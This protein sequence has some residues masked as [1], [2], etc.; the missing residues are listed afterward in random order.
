[1][2]SNRY[3]PFHLT[4]SKNNPLR[5]FT[6][7][8]DYKGA[9]Q[10]L[11]KGIVLKCFSYLNAERTDAAIYHL[12]HGRRS[13]QTIHDAHL[14]DLSEFYGIYRHLNKQKFNKLIKHLEHERLIDRYKGTDIFE[15]TER[16]TIWL[17]EH[18]HTMPFHYYKGLQYYDVD[19]MFFER[20]LLLTQVLTNS[21]NQNY[22]Y[23]P[24]IDK[25]EITEWVKQTYAHMKE[26]VHEHL[27]TLYIELYH[28]LNLLN[29]QEANLFVDRLTGYRHYGLS[30]QQLSAQYN[31]SES[32]IYLY[33]TGI[34]HRLLDHIGQDRRTYPFLNACIQDQ[35]IYQTM[36]QSA[37]QTE[38]LLS[39]GLDPEA[40]A[41]FRRLTI[42][43]IYDHIVEIALLRENFN[44]QPYVSYEEQEAIIQA[45]KQA[46]STKLKRIK[47]QLNDHISYF[48]IRLVLTTHKHLLKVDDKV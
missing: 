25:R 47:A 20:L 18:E 38:T 17:A 46:S 42:N 1:M 9:S 12:L 26:S 43:T 21:Y 8:I 29:E 48:Q 45:I 33:L 44:I 11:Y 40:V 32:D 14:Y 24:V 27:H 37:R 31:M 4:I 5:S 23:I 19:H 36:T 15:L 35:S 2:F 6:N 41:R 34:I 39:R 13:I 16:G 10:L 7:L 3:Y 22:Q 30:L 28:L